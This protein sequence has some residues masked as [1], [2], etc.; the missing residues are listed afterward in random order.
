MLTFKKLKNIYKSSVHH[1]NY[2][3]NFFESNDSV[4]TETAIE[5]MSL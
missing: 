3:V 4:V 5:R 2:F 1:S